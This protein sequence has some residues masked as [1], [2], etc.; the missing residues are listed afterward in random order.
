MILYKLRVAHPLY[1]M[2]G[3][4][5]RSLSGEKELLV[6]THPTFT[7]HQGDTIPGFGINSYLG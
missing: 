1:P 3:C 2:V 7:K 6:A 4:V 5:A